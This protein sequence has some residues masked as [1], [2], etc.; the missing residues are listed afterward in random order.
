MDN[1][2]ETVETYENDVL[3]SRLV[4]GQL[5]APQEEEAV[6]PAAAPPEDVPPPAAAQPAGQPVLEADMELPDLP[7][8]RNLQLEALSIEH[9]M[10]H[11]PKN[12]WCA[13][14]QR[15]KLMT[16]PSFRGALGR[17]VRG[18]QFG[19]LVTVDHAVL[20]AEAVPWPER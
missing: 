12:R 20:T 4:N 17:K 3:T 1:G 13:P 18:K 10:T 6:P 14:C 2:V 16:P 8:R 9:F 15:A 11:L 5:P 7:G 19:D